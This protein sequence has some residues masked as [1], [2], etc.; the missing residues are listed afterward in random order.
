MLLFFF[1][2]W[3]LICKVY[4]GIIWGFASLNQIKQFNL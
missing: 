4:C 1:T 3:N 2:D